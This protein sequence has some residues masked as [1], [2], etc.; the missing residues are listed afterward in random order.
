MAYMITCPH[1]ERTLKLGSRH[2][3]KTINCPSCAG[4]LQVPTREELD[5][6]LLPPVNTGNGHGG[7]DRDTAPSREMP[8]PGSESAQIISC[9]H[10]A[11]SLKIRDRHRG[12]T[13]RCPACRGQ[14]EVPAERPAAQ[15]EVTASSSGQRSAVSDETTPLTPEQIKEGGLAQHPQPLQEFAGYRIQSELGRGGM[16]VVYKAFDPKLKRTV[17]LKVLLS[18]EHASEEEIQR[19]FR[20]AE[21]AARLQHPNIV[22][23]HDLEVH[24]GKHFYTM[25]FV[26]GAS[27]SELID[28]NTLSTEQS[29]EIL[30]KVAR[31]LEHAHG[32]GIVHRDLKP[33][34]IIIGPDGEPKITDFGLAKVLSAG[35]GDVTHSG[36]TLSGAAMGTPYYESPEQAMGRSKDVDARSDVYALGCVMYELLAGIPPFVSANPMEIL[37]KQIEE[38]PAPPRTHRRRIP[39]DA[40]TI[41]LKCLE[42]EP[43]RRYQSAGELAEDLRRFAQREP[44]AARP[45]SISYRLGKK[46]SKHRK[47]IIASTLA[48]FC[49]ACLV[50]LGGYVLGY[51]RRS[52]VP[53]AAPAEESAVK[54][55]QETKTP[56]IAKPAAA[57]KAPPLFGEMV[58]DLFESK[59][60]KNRPKGSAPPTVAILEVKSGTELRVNLIAAHVWLSEGLTRAAGDRLTFVNR[61]KRFIQETMKA[62]EKLALKGAEYFVVCTVIG[63]PADDALQI[64]IRLTATR[65][66]QIVFARTYQLGSRPSFVSAPVT[67]PLTKP[68]A[69]PPSGLVVGV[70]IRE[71]A[72]DA[73]GKRE[74]LGSSTVQLELEKRLQERGATIVDISGLDPETRK[75]RCSVLV[76]GEVLARF[77]DRQVLYKRPYKF[78]RCL[79]SVAIVKT[80]TNEKI[81]W[82]TEPIT[83]TGMPWKKSAKTFVPPM[84]QALMAAFPK[85]VPSRSGAHA[86]WTKAQVVFGVDIADVL[87]DKDGKRKKTGISPVQQELEARLQNAGIRVLNVA[88]KSKQ[89]AG[90]S[91]DFLISGSIVTIYRDT[92]NLFGRNTAFYKCL[93]AV[94]IVALKSGRKIPWR[95]EVILRTG[96][97]STH[98]RETYVPVILESLVEALPDLAGERGKDVERDRSS[99]LL[100]VSKDAPSASLRLSADGRRLVAVYMPRKAKR[101]TLWVWQVPSRKMSR[102]YVVVK[103]YGRPTVGPRGER[104]TIGYRDGTVEIHEV[105]RGKKPVSWKAGEKRLAQAL[106]SLDG[107]W[108]ATRGYSEGLKL[109]DA[110]TG[111][112]KTAWDPGIRFLPRS[113]SPDGKF[114][115]AA[116]SEGISFRRAADG[117]E[118]KVLKEDS[119]NARGI[120]FSPN[121]LML[122][123]WHG[124]SDVRLWDLAGGKVTR[125]LRTLGGRV[126]AAA[127]SSDNKYLAAAYSPG[128]VRIWSVADGH[129]ALCLRPHDDKPSQIAFTP[130]GKNLVVR[131]GLRLARIWRLDALYRGGSGKQLKERKER[132]EEPKTPGV[133]KIRIGFIA[134]RSNAGWILTLHLRKPKSKDIAEIFYRLGP[135]G[136]FESTG[137]SRVITNPR[138]SRPVPLHYF[139]TARSQKSCKIFIKYTDSGGAEYG[140]YEI[141]FDPEKALLRQVK[142]IMQ[143]TKFTWVRMYEKDGKLLLSFSHL[144]TYRDALK[145]VKYSLGQPTVDRTFPMPPAKAKSRRMRRA[146]Q[147][148]KSIKVVYV[149]ITYKDGEKSKVRAFKRE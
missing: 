10:C 54:P 66:S 1:C 96:L 111:K 134:S 88:G 11:K 97:P 108:I 58:K 87:I 71:V 35:E 74:V 78:Y 4:G 110:K 119:K 65:T 21:S 133:E 70:D 40:Q 46:L 28:G 13:I 135:K 50:V 30:E 89:E 138:T 144:V 99:L 62:N 12:K 55:K 85:F 132:V 148:P 125:P 43:H 80:R 23:I 68:Q 101:A 61:D 18:A 24:E 57:P 139:M 2:L 52:A 93:P 15:K 126:L 38:D 127:F 92:Q 81:A 26:D 64:S 37:R 29:V 56:E 76:T 114:L 8:A 77:T 100:D 149:R 22:P 136:P 34:N 69:P 131:C 9:P 143:M 67:K 45:A 120:A 75:V 140:P 59:E 36:L 113:W 44:I 79:P 107:N 103:G 123:S 147:I 122:A 41:C 47:T 49:T 73:K 106:L 83:R 51:G 94:N 109:W 3:G 42:K 146:V 105:D 91:C 14:F 128:T 31:G 6:A 130:D 137:H 115:V 7:E 102:R 16:G 86:R 25:D 33:A 19:F 5:T 72:T 90:K 117:E 48:V 32:Q 121:G 27:L 142:S 95:A 112:L 20:E 53:S 104:F 39:I 141:F 60:L 116:G 124:D 17:A 145:E 84:V 98:T 63:M 82:Q 129:K 118:E